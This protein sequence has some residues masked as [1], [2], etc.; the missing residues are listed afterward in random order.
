MHPPSRFRLI[1]CEIMYREVCYC[2]S[3]S[4]NIVDVVFMPKGLHDVGECNMSA[5]LQAEITKVDPC[6]YAAILLGYGLC[7]NGIRGLHSSLP[8][9]LPRGHDCITLLLGSKDKYAE[10]FHNNPGTFFKST[11]WVERDAN[12]ADNKDSVISQLGMNR[13]YQEY[14]AKYGEENARYLMETLG[15]WLKNYKKLTYI[16]TGIG[17]FQPYKDQT[18]EQATKRGWEYEEIRGSVGLLLRLL[19]GFWD[20]SEFLVVPPKRS[21]APT[22]DA[23]VIGLASRDNL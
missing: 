10:Y 7:N 11:G 6:Q 2:L 22:F 3:Q 17:D 8:I 18:R 14:V 1:A 4:R 19:D 15:D 16:D 21:P 5:R 12:P 20:A 23:E 13:T 9:V